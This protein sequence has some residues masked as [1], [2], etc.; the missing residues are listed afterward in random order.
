MQSEDQREQDQLSEDPVSVVIERFMRAEREIVA[1]VIQ[2]NRSNNALNAARQEID[3]LTKA[4]E[5]KDRIIAELHAAAKANAEI[6]GTDAE[7]LDAAPND[8]V[9]GAI[10]ETVQDEKQ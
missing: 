4:V 8:G 9:S 10:A 1:F 2:R 5:E 6:L 7:T 3:R